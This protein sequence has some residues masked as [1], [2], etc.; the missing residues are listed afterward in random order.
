M[1]QHELTRRFRRLVMVS[2]PVPL[3]AVVPACSGQTTAGGDAG[4]GGSSSIGVG[5]FLGTVVMVGGTSGQGGAAGTAGRGA[6]GLSGTRALTGGGPGAAGASSAGTGGFLGLRALTGGSP[7]VAG[8][9]SVGIGGFLGTVIMLGGSS[10]SGD[11]G[12]VVTCPDAPTT[13]TGGAASV[14]NCP[15][16]FCVTV[17][18][19]TATGTLDTTQ[20]TAL[21]GRPALTCEPMASTGASLLKCHPDC[22][23]RRPDGLEQ[24]Q[25]VGC[26]ELGRY[27]TEVAHLEAASVV[28]FRAIGRQ[29]AVYGAPTSLRRAAR[30]AT[31]DEI[32]H[33]R[34]TRTLAER[35]GGRY[36]PPQVTAKPAPSLETVA[37]ENATE[38][39]VRE[40]FGAL[41]ATYQAEHATD[42]QVRRTMRRIARDE[43]RHAALAWRIAN[44]AENRLDAV[45]KGRVRA[46]RQA[47]CVFRRIRSLIPLGSDRSFR[48]IRSGIG[49]QRRIGESV[50]GLGGQFG[51]E[52]FLAAHGLAA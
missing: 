23:G 17:D 25:S 24:M 31:R 26:D 47:S 48:R 9:S 15:S 38:G 42:P 33:A 37:S 51:L 34:I 4:V 40:T 36:V 29:L 6:G 30:R 14:L 1:R 11:A 41:L 50:C 19:S 43:A 12:N 5:G 3:G 49:A 39:C 52:S 16:A 13:G 32:A 8:N 20:C 10:S 35:F 28:A 2:A 45:A 21:C 46:A 44:W 18:P 7:N 27:F 22:T